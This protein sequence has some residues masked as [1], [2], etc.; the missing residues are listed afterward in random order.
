MNSIP[1]LHSWI[2]NCLFL[3]CSCWNPKVVDRSEGPCSQE[4]KLPATFP[5]T[6][7][8]PKMWTPGATSP[9]RTKHQVLLTLQRR[10]IT[11]APVSPPLFAS[12]HPESRKNLSMPPTTWRSWA[13]RLLKLRPNT[14]KMVRKSMLEL[15]SV[16]RP[17]PVSYLNRP[18]TGSEKT[19]LNI[20]T[21]A[22]S[23]WLF[24]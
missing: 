3:F 24:I 13:H 15:S 5:D 9:S 19:S 8:W 14:S 1:G 2:N 23:K 18:V 20:A 22:E 12:L 21:K 10:R 17:H 11:A 16:S 4:A 6:S 7:K